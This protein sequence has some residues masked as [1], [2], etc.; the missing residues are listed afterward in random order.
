MEIDEDNLTPGM[1]QYVAVKQKY[2]DCLVLFRMGDFYETFYDDAVTAARD[3]EITLTSRGKGEKKA[4]L[5][6]IPYHAL[7]TYLARL[8]RKG[9]KVVIVEQIED[10]KLAKGLVKRDVVRIVTPGTVMESSILDSKSNNYLMSLYINGDNFSAAVCDISTGE[11]LVVE[12]KKIST[13]ANEIVKFSPKECIIPLTLMVNHEVMGVLKKSGVFVTDL[14]DRHFAFDNASQTVQKHFNVA[15]LE[16]FGISNS[17]QAINAA[18]AMLTYIQNTQF[19]DLSYISR[20]SLVRHSNFM[21]LD[22]STLRNLELIKNLRDGTPRGSLISVMDKTLTSM[23]S[24]MIKKWVLEPL[25]DVSE[26]NKRLDAVELLKKNTMLRE[27]LSGILKGIMDLERLISKVNYGTANPRDLL[28]LKASLMHVPFICKV[29][30]PALCQGENRLLSDV[31]AMDDFTSV[32]ALLESSIRDDAPMTI[33]EGNMIKHDFNEEL[34]Q[35]YDIKTN[36]RKYIQKIED[37]EK[38]RTGIKSMKVGFNKV[39]GYFIEVSKSNLHLVPDT[40]V[41]KQT[42]V[43]SERFITEEL[44]EQ[45][46]MILG[47]QEKIEALEYEIYHDLMKKVALH[48]GHVQ[49]TSKKIAVLDVLLSFAKVSAENNYARPEVTDSSR[50]RLF[51]CRHPV[52]EQLEKDFVPNDIILKDYEI[53]LITGPNMAGKSTVLRQVALNVLMAQIGCFC[54]ATEA[55]VGVVDRIFTRVGA[56][57][58]LSMGQSTFMV[59]M[60]EAANILNNATSKSLIILDEIG[61]GTSTFDGVALAWSI[62]EHIYNR[63]KAKTLFATHYHILN[64]LETQF[65]KINN[66]N[67]AVKEQDDNIIFLHKLV[68]GGTDKSYGIHVGKLA[69]LPREVLDRAKDIQQKLEDEDEM[70][71]KINAKKLVE[72]KTLLNM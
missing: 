18:G 16:G 49:E 44:K 48:T 71:K 13:L 64:K 19:S 32:V 54:P 6:G 51:E 60:I 7:E 22:S 34:K 29:L 23:G 63:V 61:R 14:D 41:R 58:D 11:F 33:R 3:L 39:F 20:M 28:S 65:E 35:L 24:R 38:K 52:V 56:Y 15:S 59:E 57:D 66:Y 26:I 72:Q 31:C 55:E 45:E 69:G 9:H 30:R 68:E 70:M 62:V 47:A 5:A 40:Y 37:D 50:I 4:P 36:G 10:P 27:E 42:R 2:P 25:V 67:I 43:N 53:M 1:K 12:D 8:V 17:S 21:I 46:S